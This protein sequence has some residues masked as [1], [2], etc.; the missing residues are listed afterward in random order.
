VLLA[1]LGL[2]VGFGAA[3]PSAQASGGPIYLGAAG[4][5]AGLAV[6]IGAALGVHN[7]SNFSDQ[8]ETGRMLTVEAGSVPWSTVASAS[9]GSTLYADI[10]RWAQAIKA[11]SGTTLFAY[12]H[13]PEADG[14]A[15]LGTAADFIRAYQ[16]VVTI[17]R[18]Q[19]VTNV[20]YVWQMTAYAFKAL[21]SDPR[22]AAKWYPGDAYVDNIGADAYNWYN[23]RTLSGQW[24]D[25]SVLADPVLAFAAAHSKMASFPEF[26]S[27]ADSRRA[28]WL[29]N[30]HQYFVAHSNVV[31][32]AFYFQRTPT[33]ANASHCLWPL[34]TAAEYQ[35]YGDIA[36][37][38]TF[39]P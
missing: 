26:A 18:A 13:E 27:Q 31:R 21:P 12:Q 25:L 32:A 38:T 7:Y 8:V 36:R 16:H 14:N 34:T 33:H 23:C 3:A 5:A 19:N 1:V 4:D 29:V 20:I 9:P 17:F 30:A 2:L 24:R 6:K 15:G 28:Q 37:D 39:T 11:R 10:V 35:A 22:Y